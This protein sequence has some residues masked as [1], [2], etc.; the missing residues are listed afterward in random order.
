MAS[1]DESL[2]RSLSWI[3]F[4]T[5]QQ[6]QLLQYQ[7]CR[8][9]GGFYSRRRFLHATPTAFSRSWIADS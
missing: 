2:E 7:S 8:P 6:D 3:T 9:D 5:A 4:R 1:G